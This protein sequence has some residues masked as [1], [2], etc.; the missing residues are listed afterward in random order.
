LPD[1]FSADPLFEELD[2]GLPSAV[3]VEIADILGDPTEAEVSG[4]FRY[5]APL[6]ILAIL[7][8]TVVETL[9]V[10]DDGTEEIDGPPKGPLGENDVIPGALAQAEVNPTLGDWVKLAVTEEIDEPHNGL[11]GETDEMPGALA[12]AEADP[13][14]VDWVKLAAMLEEITDAELE[15]GICVGIEELVELSTDTDERDEV[16]LKGASV[17]LDGAVLDEGRLDVLV[18]SEPD[19]DENVAV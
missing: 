6:T 15:P 19:A 12:E 3:D 17:E 10:D 2:G 1:A 11:L 5:F 7:D 18:S 13:T 14:L 4:G 16:W 9:P 8:D